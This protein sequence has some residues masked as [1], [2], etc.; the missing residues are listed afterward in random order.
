SSCD[1]SLLSEVSPT[2]EGKPGGTYVIE[3]D[4]VSKRFP[5]GTVAVE[6]FSL[7]IP[8]RKTTVF[9]GLSGSGKTTLLRMINRM[10]EPTSGDVSIDGESVLGGDPVQLRRRIGYVMQ[11]SGLLPHFTVIDN[12]ATVLRLNGVS[13]ADARERSLDLLD[14]VGLE[15]GIAGRY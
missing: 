5:D 10:V 1:S 2:L 6:D 15:R 9:V 13:K 3:F 8:S 4:S 14:T 11:N 12:V 7:V